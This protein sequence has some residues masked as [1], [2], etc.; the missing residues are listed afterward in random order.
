[1]PMKQPG[2]RGLVESK[3]AL[4]SFAGSRRYS[5]GFPG[6]KLPMAF[7]FDA[8]HCLSWIGDG[9]KSKDRGKPGSHDLY[10][11]AGRARG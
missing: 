11:P 1:M 6:E 9:T 8:V 7:D 4:L 10:V 3:G 5:A 2:R